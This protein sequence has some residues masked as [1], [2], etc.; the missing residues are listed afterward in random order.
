MSKRIICVLCDLPLDICRHGNF[1]ERMLGGPENVGG[2][3]QQK[4]E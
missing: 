2:K 3:P 1:A 4:E